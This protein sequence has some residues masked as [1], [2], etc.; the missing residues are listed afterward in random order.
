VST[1]QEAFARAKLAWEQLAEIWLRGEQRTPA[2]R[3]AL[4][5]LIDALEALHDY[6][7]DVNT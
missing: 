4:Q 1:D 5:G 2:G 7:A 6:M 3:R